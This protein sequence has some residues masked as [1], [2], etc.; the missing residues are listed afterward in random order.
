MTPAQL[1]FSHRATERTID[2]KREPGSTHDSFAHE[3]EKGFIVEWFREKTKGSRFKGALP[4]SRIVASAD[5]NNARFRRLFPQ[6]RLHF[7]SVHV[8]HP[9]IE[10][11]HPAGTFFDRR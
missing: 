10:D 9:D 7:Q 6:G 8:R 4:D 11:R 2:Q 5:E 3:L 1:P